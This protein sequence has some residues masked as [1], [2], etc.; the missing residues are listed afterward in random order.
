MTYNIYTYK[1]DIYQSIFDGKIDGG[2]GDINLD[3]YDTVPSLI[4]DYSEDVNID[5]SLGVIQI[6][7]AAFETIS[8]L[9][10]DTVYDIILDENGLYILDGSEQPI[11]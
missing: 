4:E 9:N 1:T 2:Y 10:D 7:M 3:N 11:W 5:M 6:D 8:S